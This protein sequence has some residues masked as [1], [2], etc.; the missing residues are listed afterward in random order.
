MIGPAQPEVGMR[1]D[2]NSRVQQRWVWVRGFYGTRT[3]QTGPSRCGIDD[4]A[5]TTS[6]G[7]TQGWE[8]SDQPKVGMGRWLVEIFLENAV[9]A[10][11]D[12]SP[13]LSDLPGGVAVRM[14]VDLLQVKNSQKLRIFIV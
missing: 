6:G 14:K 4:W 12:T 3:F 7:Y 2:G 5:L 10:L 1:R 13:P 11:C 9:L 8:Q